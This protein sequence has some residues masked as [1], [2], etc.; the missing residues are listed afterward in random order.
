MLPKDHKITE[1]KDASLVAVLIFSWLLETTNI[2]KE[3][4]GISIDNSSFSPTQTKTS[5]S[6]LHSVQSDLTPSNSKFSITRIKKLHRLHPGLHDIILDNSNFSIA[7]QFCVSH[8]SSSYR[9]SSVY[10]KTFKLKNPTNFRLL[11]PSE[12]MFLIFLHHI[13]FDLIA[14]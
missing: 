2:W 11:F 12:F 14:S 9:D 1:E 3:Y 8:N 6:L 13:K 10:L 4:N 7:R 5:F